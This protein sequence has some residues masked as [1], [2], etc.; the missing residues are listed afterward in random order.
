MKIYISIPITGH[1]YDTQKKKAEKIAALIQMAG[2][3]PVN[4][5][6]IP[7]PPEEGLTEKEKY[8]YY[9]SCDME[10]LLTCDAIY[11][12]QGWQESKG[13]QL[14]KAAADIYQLEQYTTFIGIPGLED[15]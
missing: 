10:Y 13:C 1:D 4:P 15:L 2:H 7:L 6:R 5:F 3:E 14:E 8:A 9:M 11:L 12:S